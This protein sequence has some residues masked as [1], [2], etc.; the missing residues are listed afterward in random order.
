MENSRNLGH[1]VIPLTAKELPLGR[2]LRRLVQRPVKDVDEISRVGA[3]LQQP[4]PALAAELAVQ[5]GP[6]PVVRLVHLDGVLAR[7][8]GEAGF[9]DLGR[10][11]EG[12]AREFLAVAAVAEAGARGVLV[13]QVDLV[14]DLAAVAAAGEFH[15][16]DGGGGRECQ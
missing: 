1:P 8:D 16:G 5:Q 6:T 2:Q 11:A 13:V 9:G 4:A 12:P 10:D 14:A 7:R 15:G 3:I